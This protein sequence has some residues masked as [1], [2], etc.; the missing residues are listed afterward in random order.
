MV[1]YKTFTIFA[2]T[3]NDDVLCLR[4]VILSYGTELNGLLSVAMRNKME[5]EMAKQE[6]INIKENEN[7]V[8]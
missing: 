3:Q 2:P 7:T 1:F 5:V 6:L 8:R 4:D